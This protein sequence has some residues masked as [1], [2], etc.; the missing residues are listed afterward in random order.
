PVPYISV[1][2]QGQVNRTVNT[3]ADGKYSFTTVPINTYNVAVIDS[4]NNL[5]AFAQGVVLQTD[6]Q[7]VG[8]DLTMI[9]VGSVTG[10]V[11]NPDQTPVAGIGVTLNSY[12]PGYAHGISGQ[13]DV[14]GVY[15]INQ[16]P[17]GN[18][19]VSA[20]GQTPT[21][22]LFGTSDGNLAGDGQTATADIH[23]T[24]TQVPITVGISLYDANGY[25]YDIGQDGGI[26]NGFRRI[27]AGNFGN[28]NHGMLLDVNANGTPTRFAGRAFATKSLNGRE[29]TLSQLDV[30]GLN[31]T[32]KIFV[33]R[34]G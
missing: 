2:L 23:L 26:Q 25:V 21:A 32:R 34:D 28:A 27:Y 20:S 8:A 19:T 11:F 12:A 3:D 14:N 9:G 10:T 33:P 31:V 30:A 13:T 17:V 15:I 4:Y 18:F 22:T 29:F 5:R 1:R 7:S 24:E 6:G 16:V